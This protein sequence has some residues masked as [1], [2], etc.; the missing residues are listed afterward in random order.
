MKRVLIVESPTKAR[1]IERYVGK[2]F[3]VLSSMGHIKDLPKTKLGVDIEGGFIPTYR[4]LP[5][6]RKVVKQL[7][8]V[9]GKADEVFIATDPDREGEAIAYHIAQEIN[10]DDAKRVLFYEITKDAV[11]S[12]LKSP[13]KIDMDRV[14]AQQARRILDRLVGYKVSPVL[15]RVVKKGLSAGRVQTVALRLICEREKEIREY[16]KGMKEK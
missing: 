4:V 7:K 11:R 8:E 12:A 10:R 2:D 5:A 13:S 1:T 14:Y 6:K 16:L 3:K 9:T 15:W